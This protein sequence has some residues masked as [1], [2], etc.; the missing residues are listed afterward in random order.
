MFLAGGVVDLDDALMLIVVIEN[1]VLQSAARVGG[2]GHILQKIERLLVDLRKRKPVIDEWRGERDLSSAITGR[3]RER[4]KIPAA[5]RCRGHEAD[6]LARI[7][8]LD[9]SLIAGEEEEPVLRDRASQR[10]AEL[11]AFQTIPLRGK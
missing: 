10:P 6:G 11:I 7:G 4:G 5:H 3:R 2:N 1:P 8:F 9:L